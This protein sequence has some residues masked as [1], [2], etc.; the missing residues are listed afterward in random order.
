[1]YDVAVV[2]AGPAGATAALKLAEAGAHVVLLEKQE[3]PRYKTCG[4][5]IVGRARRLLNLD[6]GRVVER[7]CRAVRLTLLQSG[8]SFHVQRNEPII[9]MTMR[10]SLD[11]RLASAAQAAGAVLRT[12]SPVDAL[13]C[14][15]GYVRLVT[16]SGPVSAKFVIAA[17]G[18]NSVVARSAGWKES[19]RL[20]PAIEAEVRLRDNAMDRHIGSARFDF[21][22]PP[23]GY[24]W[25]FPKREHLSI[26]VLTMR[27]GRGGLKAD[28]AQYLQATGI[29]DFVTEDRHGFVIPLSARRDGFARNRVLLVGDSAGFADPLTGEGIS[30]AIQSGRIAAEALLAEHFDADRSLAGYERCVRGTIVRELVAARM[31]ARL[32]YGTRRF[33]TWAFGRHGKKLTEAVTDVMMGTRS[34]HASLCNVRQYLRRLK[35]RGG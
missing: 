32:L 12:G 22:L 35:P 13:S 19:R 34:Y 16:K 30:F 18:V 29:K 20:I 2:G 17:D 24:A 10:A 25:L 14:A 23:H 11:H 6:I 7:E 3:L 28:Y 33:R 9:S 31:L 21:D 4:G 8:L 1:M 26:G 15:A 5:G 27:R